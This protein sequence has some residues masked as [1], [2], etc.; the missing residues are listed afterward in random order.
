MKEKEKEKNK[1]AVLCPTQKG[2]NIEKRDMIGKESAYTGKKHTVFEGEDMV[3]RASLSRFHHSP[4]ISWGETSDNKDG[5]LHYSGG[6]CRHKPWVA[7]L[8]VYELVATGAIVETGWSVSN[9][10][11]T[12]RLLSTQS[13]VASLAVYELVATGAIVET[14][15]LVSNTR[16][17]GTIYDSLTMSFNQKKKNRVRLNVSKRN[18]ITNDLRP[19]TWNNLYKKLSHLPSPF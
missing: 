14:G 7:S 16:R 11:H 1:G 13:W 8:A 9:T 4:I 19:F 18:K 5:Q 6:P 17:T 2:W 15:W 3:T 10:R 12:G